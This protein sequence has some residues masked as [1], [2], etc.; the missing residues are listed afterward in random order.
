MATHNYQHG[1]FKCQTQVLGLADADVEYCPNFLDE[2]AAWGL[3]EHLL[4]ETQWRQE[5]IKVYGKEHL[6]PRLSC[7]VGAQWMDYSYSGLTMKPVPFNDALW[8][9]KRSIEAHSQQTF[10]SVLLNYYRN[11]RDSN[12]WHSD[13]EPELG[14]NPVIASLSLGAPR[15]FQLRSKRDKSLKQTLS[16]EHGS[17]LV[18]RGTTQRCWQHQIPK[19]ANAASRINLT[20]R[21]IIR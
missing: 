6:T 8:S 15:D 1:L 20:F 4:Q 17:L 11:G 19:R 2:Q 21:T 16:L 9:L 14:D 18:M 5:T 10:N 13:D 7:W 12:G 3:Y